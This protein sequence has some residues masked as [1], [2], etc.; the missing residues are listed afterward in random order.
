MTQS[1][2]IYRVG[3]L[4]TRFRSFFWQVDSLQCWQAVQ[5]CSDLQLTLSFASPNEK[6]MKF[7]TSFVLA[8]SLF[9]TV[10]VEGTLKLFFNLFLRPTLDNVCE[11]SL[12]ALGIDALKCGCDVRYRGLG[13]GFLGDISCATTSAT[14][15][16]DYCAIG[17]LNASVAGSLFSGVNL[18]GDVKGCFTIETGIDPQVL[19]D[20][21]L[22]ISFVPEG[23]ALKTCTAVINGVTCNNCAVC[24]SG[25]AFT[26][27]CSNVD[28][29]PDPSI[30][31]GGPAISECIGLDLVSA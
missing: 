28:L 17:T 16:S 12:A 7:T 24:S 29:L 4:A 26:F 2:V 31:V 5:L 21:E 14:C 20:P 30:T 3:H 15:F 23:L 18:A 25:T 6:K 11:K 19:A 1:S 22:C 9:P 8:L 13:R 27:N 10:E